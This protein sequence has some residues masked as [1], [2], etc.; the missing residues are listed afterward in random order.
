MLLA[1][2]PCRRLPGGS[3]GACFPTFRMRAADQGHV[4]STPD[5]TWPVSGHPP[6]SSR[7]N[8]KHPV[9]TSYKGV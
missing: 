9:L 3:I 6:G 7:A 5:A 4:T 8:S 2:A 1:R